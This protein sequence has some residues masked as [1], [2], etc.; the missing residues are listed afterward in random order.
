[1]PASVRRWLAKNLPWKDLNNVT[2][3]VDVMNETSIKILEEKKKAL[4]KGD[5]AVVHQVAEGRDIMS[6]LRKC[7]MLVHVQTVGAVL[8]AIRSASQYF[9]IR[10]YEAS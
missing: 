3:I 6:I 1:M 5:D 7:F 10:R 4:K 9:C 2:E 8:I